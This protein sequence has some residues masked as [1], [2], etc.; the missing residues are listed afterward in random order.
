MRKCV[1]EYVYLTP[2]IYIY[3][4]IYIYVWVCG[5]V[6]VCVCVLNYSSTLIRH[7]LYVFPSV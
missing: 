5:C 7:Y 4:Y 2:L 6:C 3:I 1:C